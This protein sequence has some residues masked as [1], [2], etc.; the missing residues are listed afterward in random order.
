MASTTSKETGL[1]TLNTGL[2]QDATW[3]GIVNEF[4]WICAGVNREILRKCPTDWSKYFGIGGLILFTALM[5]SLSGGYA[6]Y[7]IFDS[8]ILAIFFGFFWGA[9]IFNLDRFIVNTM[10]SDGEPTIS[11]L[12]LLAGLPRLIIAV[13]LGIVIS[14]PLEMK[15]FEDRIETQITLD[16][17]ERVNNAKEKLN[18]GN[19]V[20]VDRRS[21][22]ESERKKIN[23]RL[24]KAKEDVVRESEG[25]GHSGT[26]G[27]GPIYEDKLRLKK[28][29]ENEL[30]DWEKT[31]E[32][33]LNE[34][35]NQIAKNNNEVGED[36]SKST[37][38]KGFCVRY[39][40]FSNAKK[41]SSSIRIVSLFIMLML[42]VIEVAPTFF[43]MMVSSGTYDNLLEAERHK[44]KVISQKFISDINDEINTEIK[45]STGRN[46]QK[47]D[48]ELK[49]NKEIL[50]QVASV[51]SEILQEAI[52]RWR[53]EELQKVQKD[54]SQYFNS[55]KS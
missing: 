48:L 27:H 8:T 42:I 10:Y 40:A 44:K 2:P 13:F 41:A 7:T 53:E 49:T 43:K 18:K 22:L 26:S 33:E 16:N 14:T 32:G 28:E 24:A 20:L 1:P 38:N 45:I 51:Q 21:M 6:F 3:G 55:Q 47:L 19:K 9:L 11:G 50:E 23:D 35:R 54:P 31:Y 52:K 36:I 30:K 37:E 39:E 34:I 5:A 25:T 17:I 46:Q 29:I 4:F 12:E 15:I